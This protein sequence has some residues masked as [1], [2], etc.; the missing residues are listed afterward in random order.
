MEVF[1]IGGTQERGVIGEIHGIE[2]S[3][4]LLLPPGGESRLQSLTIRYWQPEVPTETVE[5]IVRTAKNVL[6]GGEPIQ[7]WFRIDPLNSDRMIGDYNTV[8]RLSRRENQERKEVPLTLIEEE[9]ATVKVPY[10][11]SL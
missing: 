7:Q 3:Y 8:K 10:K 6:I 2:G 1:A 11:P 9:I 4:A 5:L